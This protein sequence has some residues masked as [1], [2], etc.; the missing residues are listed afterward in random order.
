MVN[1]HPNQPEIRQSILP[2]SVVDIPHARQNPDPCELHFIAKNLNN[3]GCRW[4]A[5]GKY[6]TAIEFLREALEISKLVACN[7][8]EI[9]KNCTSD[10]CGFQS[11][12]AMVEEEDQ[13]D[14]KSYPNIQERTNNANFDLDSRIENK[15]ETVFDQIK[16]QGFM[17]RRPFVVDSHCIDRGCY[18]GT[19][20]SFMILFNIALAHHMKATDACMNRVDRFETLQHSLTLYQ[21]AYEMHFHC[22]QEWLQSSQRHPKSSSSGSPPQERERMDEATADAQERLCNLVNIRLMTLVTNNI[23]DI[24][25]LAGD[26][27][28]HHQCLE[29]LLVA[30]MFMSHNFEGDTV[31]SYH[32]REGIFENLS[33]LLRTK[34][35]AA[36]A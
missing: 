10:Y 19:T 36:A 7:A 30:I 35:Y 14:E 6:D 1:I 5:A 29:H 31:L 34:E 2:S 15:I 33:P 32:E 16:D 23:G 3:Q 25:R 17:F 20:L 8:T 4:I 18:M 24:H 27:N 28:K 22:K 9:P 26:T 12:L 13:N 21:L 11:F